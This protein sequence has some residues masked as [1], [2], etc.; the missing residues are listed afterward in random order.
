MKQL[1]Q[2]KDITLQQWVEFYMKFGKE[3]DR[4]YNAIQLMPDGQLR[5]DMYL[6]YEVDCAEQTYSFYAGPIDGLELSEIVIEYAKATTQWNEDLITAMATIAEPVWF[7]GKMWQIRSIAG[8]GAMSYYDFIRIQ[9]A[10]EILAE[11]DEGSIEKVYEIID[12][13]F[14]EESSPINRPE[15]LEQLKML[16][17]NIGYAILET[18][19]NANAKQHTTVSSS[20]IE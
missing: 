9:E 19:R 12:A 10:A 6:V 7:M 11:L 14:K 1:P 20:A 18:I 5:D 17:L 2:L 16:P 13:F 3:L 15:R 4:R 8:S